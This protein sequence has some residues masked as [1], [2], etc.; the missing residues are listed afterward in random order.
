MRCVIM[1]LNREQY[2]EDAGE[3]DLWLYFE[4]TDQRPSLSRRHMPMLQGF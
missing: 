2:I 1:I 4:M 3:I